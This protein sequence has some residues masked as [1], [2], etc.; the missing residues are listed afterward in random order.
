V[1]AGLVLAATVAIT[2]CSSTSTNLGPE[3]GRYPGD[4]LP[5]TVFVRSEVAP[6]PVD[7]ERYRPRDINTAT[8]GTPRAAVMAPARR[9]SERRPRGAGGF[10]GILLQIGGSMLQQAVNR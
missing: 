10:V 6:P 3:L 4:P 9:P 7:I 8:A 1:V 5:T 2:G